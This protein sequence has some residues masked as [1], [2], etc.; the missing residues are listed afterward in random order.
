MKLKC[1]WINCKNNS[2][3]ISRDEVRKMINSG[4]DC[5]ESS[6]FCKCNGIVTLAFE[7]NATES[8]DEYLICENYEDGAKFDLS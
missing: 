2:F 3:E 1:P 4:I 8:E 6:E 7:T 5:F